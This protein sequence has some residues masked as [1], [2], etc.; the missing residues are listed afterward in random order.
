M[1]SQAVKT[2]FKDQDSERLSA[3]F[4]QE[5]SCMI[6]IADDWRYFGWTTF[7][8]RLANPVGLARTH[9]RPWLGSWRQFL[10][11]RELYCSWA[12]TSWPDTCWPSIANV[13]F[14]SNSFW[15][16]FLL[17]HRCNQLFKWRGTKDRSQGGLWGK[18][19]ITQFGNNCSN[20]SPQP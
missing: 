3:N 6:H 8:A 11:W 2:A 18:E 5:P 1:W 14:R 16:W 12:P 17:L 13:I 20:L 15:S 4:R 19:E 9:W 7:A 10:S